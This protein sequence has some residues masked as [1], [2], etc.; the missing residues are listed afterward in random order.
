MFQRFVAGSAVG[1]LVIAVAALGVVT[2]AGVALPRTWPLTTIWCFV[3]FAWGIWAMLTPR[4]WLPQG[5]PYWG[6]ILGFLGGIMNAFVLNLPSRIFAVPVSVLGR[7][8]AVAVVTVAYYFLWM[9]VRI[10]YGKLTSAAPFTET[11]SGGPQLKKA[12]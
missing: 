9:L 7:V 1:A 4:T 2:I 12:A 8:V 6:A 3:P 11:A 5:L 10:A